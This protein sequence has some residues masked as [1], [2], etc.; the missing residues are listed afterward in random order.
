MSTIETPEIA[1]LYGALDSAA[2]EDGGSYNAH[3]L[4][5][6]VRSSNRLA[7]KGQHLLTLPF[8]ERA[9]TPSYDG[10][11]DSLPAWSYW[12]GLRTVC[13]TTQWVRITPRIPIPKRPGLRTAAVRV[14]ARVSDDHTV[15]LQ[16][17]TRAAPFDPRASS[18][19]ANVVELTGDSD[20]DV[21]LYSGSGIPIHHGGYETVELYVRG[22]RTGDLA[23]TTDGGTPNQSSSLGGYKPFANRVQ[24]AST[25]GASWVI[26]GWGQSGAE[27]VFYDRQDQELAR[28]PITQVDRENVSSGY[29]ELHFAP[30]LT[31]PEF[32]EAG[33]VRRYGGPTNA[34]EL[35][36]IPRLGIV[37]FS[38]AAEARTE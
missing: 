20:E 31:E 17:A 10:D 18:G 29:Y 33:F 4:R 6:I 5:E 14:D 35:Y 38:M 21:D 24:V 9:S 7:G 19:S 12:D 30:P 16:V 15:L 22:V 37:C 2:F 34:F 13:P 11:S 1:S 25:A 26:P 3:L 27:I 23:D 36:A 8:P 28:R 32:Q